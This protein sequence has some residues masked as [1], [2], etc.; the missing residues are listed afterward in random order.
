MKRAVWAWG[1]AGADRNYIKS[2]KCAPAVP[3][4]N[5]VKSIKHAVWAWGSAGAVRKYIKS[6]KRAAREA[7]GGARGGGY[8][9]P[10]HVEIDV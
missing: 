3:A 6:M 4:R 5:R 7:G 10:S 1:S 8:G 9:T 2:M